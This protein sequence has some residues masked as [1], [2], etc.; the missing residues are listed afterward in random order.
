MVRI[1][2]E[3]AIG[4]V[5]VAI[6]LIVADVTGSWDLAFVVFA[7]GAATAIHGVVLLLLKMTGRDA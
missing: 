1:A 2:R 4:A 7:A 3:I 5:L 6:A